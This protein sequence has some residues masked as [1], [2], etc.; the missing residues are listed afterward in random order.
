MK[1]SYITCLSYIIMTVNSFKQKIVKIYLEQLR[2]K[3][4]QI[5]QKK[6]KE[7]YNFIKIKSNNSMDEHYKPVN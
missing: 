6:I 5:Y 4:I 3:E 2:K 7:Q 1:F